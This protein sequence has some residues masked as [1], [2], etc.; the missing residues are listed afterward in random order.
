MRK[1][2]PDTYL[3]LLNATGFFEETQA[4]SLL[5]DVEELLKIIGSSQ[6]TTRKSMNS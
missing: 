3:Q 1:N 5:K 2:G 4:E 6:V